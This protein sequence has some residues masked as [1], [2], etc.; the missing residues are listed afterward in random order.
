MFKNHKPS[1]ETLGNICSFHATYVFNDRGFNHFDATA[2]LIKG[3]Y[4]CHANE[5]LLLIPLAGP[6]S[7]DTSG[8]AYQ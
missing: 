2:D 8:K 4:P 3:K 7:F 5:A 1:P 6:D